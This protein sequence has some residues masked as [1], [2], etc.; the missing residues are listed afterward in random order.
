MLSSVLGV[1]SWP[2]LAAVAVVVGAT[3]G[4][5]TGFVRWVLLAIKNVIQEEL[6]PLVERVTRLEQ[7]KDI[8]NLEISGIKQVTHEHSRKLDQI[9]FVD[10]ESE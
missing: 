2:D 6:R 10:E 4:A 3:M 5:A 7:W 8:V 9:Q 1:D